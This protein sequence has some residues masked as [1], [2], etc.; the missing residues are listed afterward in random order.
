[1]KSQIIKYKNIEEEN[2]TKIK[3]LMEKLTK[4]NEEMRQKSIDYNILNNK[5]LT[6]TDKLKF[7][8]QKLASNELIQEL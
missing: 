2:N 4:I 3:T 1:M 7:E 5:Y 6:E 8:N